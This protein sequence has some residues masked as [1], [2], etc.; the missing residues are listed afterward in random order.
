[1]PFPSTRADPE[2][3]FLKSVSVCEKH[4]CCILNGTDPFVQRVSSVYVGTP[5]CLHFWSG[6]GSLSHPNV[7]SRKGLT[8]NITHVNLYLILFYEDFYSLTKYNNVDALDLSECSNTSLLL[9]TMSPRHVL[10]HTGKS[11]KFKFY[12]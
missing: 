2:R 6:R 7:I 10:Y 5:V 11:Y 12:E 8:V 9:K 1:M 4:F 3:I